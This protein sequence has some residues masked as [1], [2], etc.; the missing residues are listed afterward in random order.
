MADSFYKHVAN[1]AKWSTMTE[2]ASKLIV[3]ISTIVLAR[4]L[5]PEDFGILVTATMV[6]SFAEIFT[7]AGF[8]KY[9]IQH[10]FKTDEAKLK[11]STVAFW[12]NFFISLIVWGGLCLF[13]K[14]IATLVGC[15]GKE[16]VIIISCVCI[17]IASF[18]SIQTALLKKAL[19][20]KVLFFVRMIGIFIPL[21]ITIP[22]AYCTRSYW[23][24]IVGM[25]CLNA[26][27]AII[28]TV[29]SPWKPKFFFKWSILKEMF[30]FSIWSMFESVS[31][32][33][34]GYIDIF[35]VGS[36][37]NQHFLGVYRTSMT[38]VAQITTLVTSATT[39]VLY[40]SL[41]HLQND[42]KAFESLFF[43]FQKLVGI[44]VIPLGFGIYMFRSLIVNLL[45]G[46]QWNEAVYFI[47]LWGLTSSITIVL[48]HYSSEVYRSKGKPKLSV[49]VQILHI[50]A[51]LPV[52]LYFVHD[53]FDVLCTARSLVRLELIGV[54]LIFMYF[55]MKFSPYKMILNIF[56]AFISSVVMLLIVNWLP[57]SNNVVND[58]A[59][60]LVAIVTYFAVILLF[61][62]ERRLLFGM[63]KTNVLERMRL[64]INFK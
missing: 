43:R 61:P 47:G 32:W 37:L 50:A 53:D 3:P 41:S 20:F 22:V 8:H 40:S 18:S 39:P 62:N 46:E 31:I 16:S 15:S 52:V 29:E 26:A 12:C 25:I 6:I 19:N 10:Q 44:L 27:T 54:N 64:K 17:P 14:Q 55:I 28:L 42:E 7:D 58:F 24:L 51:L 9:L 21:F 60:V 63:V 5:T 33:F 38:T 49:F 23:S 30:S 35:I 45:L 2:L 4:L 56:P 48:A 57:E 13:S 34:T 1:A 59:Y 36:V 11:A